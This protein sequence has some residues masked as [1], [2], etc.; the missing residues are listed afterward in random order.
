[1]YLPFPKL[2]NSTATFI[3]WMCNEINKESGEKTLKNIIKN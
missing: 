2:V 3:L 1:M